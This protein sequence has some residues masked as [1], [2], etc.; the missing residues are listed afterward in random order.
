MDPDTSAELERVVD[1]LSQ[2]DQ[3]ELQTFLTNELQKAKVQHSQYYY[4]F[5]TVILLCSQ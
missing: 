2:K 3:Q 5:I 1:Q 4:H